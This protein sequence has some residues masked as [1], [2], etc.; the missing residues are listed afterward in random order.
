MQRGDALLGLKRVGNE[1]FPIYIWHIFYVLSKFSYSCNFS[2]S[3]LLQNFLMKEPSETLD[4]STSFDFS[5]SVHVPKFF[6][7]HWFI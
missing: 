5:M 2:Y 3:M 7:Y 4:S 1:R 6:F